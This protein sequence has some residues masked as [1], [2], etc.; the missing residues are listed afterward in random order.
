ML[1]LKTKL[2]RKYTWVL[3]HLSTPNSNNTCKPF[4]LVSYIH[5]F[6]KYR[7]SLP[8]VPADRAKCC[9]VCSR[10]S[11]QPL[12]PSCWPVDHWLAGLYNRLLKLSL[13]FIDD[14]MIEEV[15]SQPLT[16]SC[17]SFFLIWSFCLIF[18]VLSGA[19]T[20]FLCLHFT[21]SR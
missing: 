19:T 13:W 7:W 17:F 14:V 1:Y 5:W 16:F 4:H 9:H 15:K 11:C 21:F 12:Q 10:L 2:Y 20:G 8:C 6:F 18:E 3:Q